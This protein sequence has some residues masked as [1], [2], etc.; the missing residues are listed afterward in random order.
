MFFNPTWC[1]NFTWYNCSWWRRP[2][3]LTPL[4]HSSNYIEKKDC[5]DRPHKRILGGTSSFPTKRVIPFPRHKYLE[6]SLPSNIVHSPRLWGQI[7]PPLPLDSSESDVI[8]RVEFWNFE[9]A[10]PSA[11]GS[12]PKLP[13]TRPREASLY[14]CEF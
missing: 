13:V 6:F 4:I 11:A 9:W 8:C 10:T 5:D 1:N 14:S 12:C 2:Q 3:F 7:S